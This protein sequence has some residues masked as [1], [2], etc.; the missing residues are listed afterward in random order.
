MA[1]LVDPDLY[2]ELFWLGNVFITI[3]SFREWTFGR[4]GNLREGSGMT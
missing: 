1:K 2:P 3:Q 4:Y